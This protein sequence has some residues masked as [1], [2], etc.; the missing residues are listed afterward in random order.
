MKRLYLLL[1]LLCLLTACGEESPAP[2]AGTAPRTAPVESLETLAKRYRDTVLTVLDIS[3]REWQG[4]N[5]I[6][7][8]LSVPLDP[9]SNLQPYL[10]VNQVNGSNVEGAWVLSDDKRVLYFTATQPQTRYEVVVN[11]GLPALTGASLAERVTQS[12]TT[13]N[14]NPAI[15]FASQGS[16]LPAKLS[17]GIPITVVNVNAVDINFHRLNTDSIGTFLQTLNDSYNQRFYRFDQLKKWGKLVY[18]GRFELNPPP[19]TVQKKSIAVEDIEALQEPGVYV[20][21]MEE[22]GSYDYRRNTT[23]FVVTDIGLQ[24]RVYPQSLVVM[25]Q[26]LANGKTLAGITVAILDQQGNVLQQRKTSPE[27]DARFEGP[28]NGGRFILA[29]DDRQMAVLELTGAALDLSEFEL[30][31]RPQLPQEAFV[32]TPRD[33]FRPGEVVDF[34]VLLRNG[35]GF[36]EKAQTL[37]IEVHQPDGQLVQ[38]AMLT[39]QDMGYY[40]YR[41]ALPQASVTGNWRFDVTNLAG[42]TVTY[43]FKVEE[44]LPERMA[45]EFNGG[46]QEALQFAAADA[47]QIPVNGKY[48]YGA[49]AAGNRLSNSVQVSLLRQPLP[50]FKGYLFGNELEAEASQKFDLP[51]QFMD[52]AGNALVNIESRWS[53]V[54]SPLQVQLLA[55]LFESGGR[56]VV[57]SYRAVVWPGNGQLGV[58]PSFG[59]KNPDA[60]SVVEFDLINVDSTGKLQALQNVQIN[61]VREDRQYYWEYDDQQGWHY[62][63]TEKEYVERSQDV[64]L[65]AQIGNKVSF[66][67]DWGRYR[68]EVKDPQTGALTSVRFHAGEDWYAWWR[69]SQNADKSIRP[70]AVTLALDKGGYKAGDVARLQINSPHAGEAVVL[71]EADKLLWLQ[72]ITLTDTQASV[73]IPVSSEWNRHDTYIS[74]V[75]LRPASRTQQITPNRAFGLIHLPLDRA[76]R[77]LQISLN[78]PE[79]VQPETDLKSEIQVSDSSGQ[80]FANGYVTLAAVDVGV[81]NISDFVTPDP[82]QGF[83]GQR[84][85]G[86]DSRDM[87]GRII[88]LNAFEKARIRFGGDADLARGGKEP[89][90]D[91]QIVSLFRQP[92]KLDAQ[93]KANIDL[94]LP[95]FNGKVRLM[96]LAFGE[97]RFGNAEHETII[98]AP[99]V[100]QLGVPRFI[101]LGDQ[102]QAV[103]DLHNL[104]GAAQKLQVEITTANGLKSAS[105]QQ[106]IALEQ[107]AK[108]TLPFTIEADNLQQ[109]AIHIK[110]S[111]EGF[112]TLERQWNIGIRPAYPA[113]VREFNAVMEPADVLNVPP[114]LLAGLHVPSSEVRLG[115]GNRANLNLPVHIRDLLHY[116]YGCLEQTSSGA[117]PYAL[118]SEQNQARFQMNPVTAQQR[119]ERIN[120]AF[121]RIAGMQLASG[122]FGLWD[123]QSPE[124][125]WLTAYVTDFML[126]VQEQ[127]F[128]VPQSMLERAL[129]RLGE[130]V[131]RSGSLFENRYTD[132]MDHY[133]FAYKA[134]AGYVLAR[135]HK[136][137]LA[138][139][140]TLHDRYRKDA[141]SGLPLLHLALALQE[142]GDQARA[143]VALKEALI[144]I[145]KTKGYLA[146]YGSPVRDQAMMIYLLLKH[147]LHTEHAMAL[148]FELANTLKDQRWLSTQERNAL[149]MAGVMLETT[150]S[151]HWLAKFRVGDAEN[152]LAQSGVAYR[153]LEGAA[154]QQQIQVQ[155]I[156]NGRLYVSAQVSG[157][158]LQTPAPLTD[159]YQIARQYFDAQGKA[160]SIKNVRS[161]DLVIVHLEIDS[162]DMAPDSLVIDMIPAGFELENQNLEHA[163]KLD[164]FRIDGKTIEQLQEYTK[165]VHQEYRDDRFVA[166]LDMRYGRSHLFYLMRAVTPGDYRVPPPYVE[167][168]YRARRRGIGATELTT[169]VAP[170]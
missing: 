101:A 27:G 108:T 11:K 102:A 18:S 14:V 132:D 138:S 105:S 115:L 59:D 78:A 143:E 39:A 164:D 124:E 145:R 65:Q 52:Q 35:D 63:F 170:R 49:P 135:L 71:V 89:Q 129:N 110:I 64:A 79:K 142:S 51:D 19:N 146:D 117:Y 58:R 3:E 75:V 141:E 56:P 149:F 76:E 165:V 137:S 24:A 25:T 17:N 57:R 123:D 20:A 150:S 90:S 80:P 6:A 68:L 128:A 155:N 106:T 88:E 121:T 5:A 8:T 61:L 134:Y 15:S 100:T 28:L 60:N 42:G 148:S 109:G 23:Y 151:E 163:I 10:E 74:V 152:Q 91:V 166:A 1:L 111:G 72:R 159:D 53:S 81:L 130:Y 136:A 44:F 83:F 139:L 125:H 40:Y 2:G 133:R 33:L 30:G 131:N 12:L 144:K 147:Q 93:G 118:A 97:S 22:A 37:N 96:A 84:R 154:L 95:Y 86:V 169:H 46:K 7:V 70:D 116:P 153:K 158:P 55:S 103:L 45:L 48:L 99:L 34:N 50:Q 119:A 29:S 82:F 16:V 13:R 43:P 160:A 92:V 66:N 168:M 9:K 4:K 104:S 113:Q 77:K 127:G 85:Y 38:Q 114:S 94:P 107:D 162:K 161:G 31:Q 157:Y 32:Y 21:V 41:F 67:V 122:G 47:V 87:Y 120:A 62:E 73:E 69:A 167:D 156:G 26:S 112:A 140:R 54:K 98:A 126:N 36:L